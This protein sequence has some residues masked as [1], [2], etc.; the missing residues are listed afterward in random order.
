MADHRTTRRQVS[1]AAAVAT[2]LTLTACTATPT[3][4]APNAPASSA[5]LEH[6]HGLGYDPVTGRTYAAAHSGVWTIPTDV[7]PDTYPAPAPGAGPAEQN[8]PIAERVQ[9]TMGFTVTAEGV[10]YASGHPDPADAAASAA[11]PNLGLI[12]STDA[13]GTWEPV[14]LSGQTDFHDLATAELED[15]TT[16]VY[17]YDASDGRIRRSDDSGTTWTP[18]ATVALRDLTVDPDRPDRVYATTQGGVQVSDDAAST[19]R[20]LD[21]APTLY[22]VEAT[23][24][25]ALAGIDVDGTVWTGSADGA[26]E[27][28]GVVT[29]TPEAFTLVGGETVWVL[30]ADERGIVASDDYGVTWTVL[31][32]F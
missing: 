1:I 23:G 25:G 24:G 14:S 2:L 30:A 17:G 11:G 19:F 28:H 31:R 13:A 12:R 3:P 20:P 29:G 16:R 32:S 5:T 22:L 4:P 21:G 10:F 15:G 8:G 26:W 18:V 6:V 7:L 9:D 27:Q